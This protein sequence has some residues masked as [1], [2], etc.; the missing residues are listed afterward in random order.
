CRRL[1][2]NCERLIETTLSM[3][4]LAFVSLLLKRY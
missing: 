4:K 3:V 1:W 2:K